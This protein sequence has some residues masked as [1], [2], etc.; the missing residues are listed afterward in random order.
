MKR[1]I[2]LTRGHDFS[3][4][5]GEIHSF[6][7]TTLNIN[8]RIPWSWNP[9]LREIKSEDDYS[10]NKVFHTG[11]A[12]ELKHRKEYQELESGNICECCGKKLN[13]ISQI[14]SRS[15]SLCDKCDSQ[16]I[17]S[18][19]DRKK[20]ALLS[21][22]DYPMIFGGKRQENYWTLWLNKK[23]NVEANDRVNRNQWRT[24]F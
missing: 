5:F 17:Q 23:E 11:Y 6:I 19:G 4:N 10:F 2:D 18:L 16:L 3:D 12:S 15:L 13:P 9:K 7:L 20:D 24:N 8:K 22:R 14:T 1:N 21:I